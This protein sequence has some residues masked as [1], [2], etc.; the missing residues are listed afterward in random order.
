MPSVR[1]IIGPLRRWQLL[2]LGDHRR[3]QTGR[4]AWNGDAI[5]EGRQCTA[6]Q[7]VRLII[8]PRLSR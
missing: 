4:I 1:A 7:A 5:L 3:R 8:M 2:N 6:Y